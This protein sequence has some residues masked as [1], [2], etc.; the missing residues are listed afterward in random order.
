MF[1]DRVLD[2]TISDQ[3]TNPSCAEFEDR[4]RCLESLFK[5]G[6]V[7]SLGPMVGALDPERRHPMSSSAG[8]GFLKTERDER[9]KTRDPAV[10]KGRVLN[11]LANGIFLSTHFRKFPS[12]APFLYTSPPSTGGQKI[13]EKR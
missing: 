10:L 7:K 1:F 11:N 12:E 5:K 6:T 3:P 9:E 2:L 13:S 8:I 4:L